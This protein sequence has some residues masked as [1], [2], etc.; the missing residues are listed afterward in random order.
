[1]KLTITEKKEAPLLSRTEVKAE[2]TFDKATPST[3]QLKQQLASTL[4]ADQKL[5]V[6]KKIN[7]SF[8]S[9][10]AD[11]VAYVYSDE[12]SMKLIEPKQKEKKGAPGEKP[13]EAAPAENIHFMKNQEKV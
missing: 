3:E 10:K 5:I 8:G 6:I 2:L 9:T 12:K 4:S 13:A 1:M 7:T 11:T